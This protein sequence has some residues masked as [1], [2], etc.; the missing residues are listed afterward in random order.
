[1][2]QAKY[3]GEELGTNNRAEVYALKDLMEWL[4]NNP[5]VWKPPAIVVYGDSQLIINFCNR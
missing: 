1:V 2:A 4:A 5:K 3:Y